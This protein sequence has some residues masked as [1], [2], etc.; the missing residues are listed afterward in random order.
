MRASKVKL[1]VFCNSQR[2]N[3]TSFNR[4]TSISIALTVLQNKTHQWMIFSTAMKTETE[5]NMLL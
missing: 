4:Q 3:R 5:T 1:T 2:I